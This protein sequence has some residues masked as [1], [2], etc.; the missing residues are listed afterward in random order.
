MRAQAVKQPVY[1]EF[2]CVSEG[3]FDEAGGYLSRCQLE[4]AWMFWK[5]L[6]QSDTYLLHHAAQVP[7]AGD[8]CSAGYSL[9]AS[10][11]TGDMQL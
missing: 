10:S 4:A 7:Q 1:P 11:V 9:R 5:H 3:K 2:P 6:V 8:K